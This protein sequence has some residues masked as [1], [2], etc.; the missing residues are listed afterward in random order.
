MVT[1]NFDYDKSARAPNKPSEK[2]KG[3]LGLL[4]LVA[5]AF[6]ALHYVLVFETTVEVEDRWHRVER[7]QDAGLVQMRMIGTIGGVAAAV[8]GG[9]LVSLGLRRQ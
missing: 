1:S 6:I 3:L 9:V 4:L 5:G 7:V 2:W 8:A